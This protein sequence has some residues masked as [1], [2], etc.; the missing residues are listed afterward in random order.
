MHGVQLALEDHEVQGVLQVLLLSLSEK[1]PELLAP[2][3]VLALT[4]CQLI[5]QLCQAVWG[6][7]TSTLE[8]GFCQRETNQTECYPPQI[9]FM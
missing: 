7:T 5:H 4:L 9:Y 2:R 1:L 6:F 3:R 8:I